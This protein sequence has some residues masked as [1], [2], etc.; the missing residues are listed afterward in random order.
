[1]TLNLMLHRIAS[2]VHVILLC[3]SAMNS[4]IKTLNTVHHYYIFHL[5]IITINI[6]EALTSM[7]RIASSV[8]SNHNPRFNDIYI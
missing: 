3:C 1:M 8:P 2:A 5:Q 4:N 7:M 6:I